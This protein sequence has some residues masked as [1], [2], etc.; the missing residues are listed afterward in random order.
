MRRVR[1]RPAMV[2]IAIFVM[3]G[4]GQLAATPAQAVSQPTCTAYSQDRI[5]ATDAT[6]VRMRYRIC[7]NETDTTIQPTVQIQFDWPTD[8]S[9]SIGFPPAMQLA[10]PMSRLSKDA[11][12]DL[13]PSGGWAYLI[14]IQATL[15]NGRKYNR[16][17]T[18]TKRLSLRPTWAH[19]RYTYSCSLPTLPRLDGRTVVFS[20]GP[21]ADIRNDGAVPFTLTSGAVAFAS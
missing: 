21:R 9:L 19:P 11:S 16:T 6:W 5:V 13:G 15:P 18:R 14:P 7:A 12:V 4:A 17:C 8:C 3:L 20:G 2:A 1:K 10:C